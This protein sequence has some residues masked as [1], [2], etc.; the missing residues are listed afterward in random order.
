VKL[1]SLHLESDLLA[2]GLAERL[3]RR[4]LHIPMVL[5]EQEFQPRIETDS[6]VLHLLP[7]HPLLVVSRRGAEASSSLVSLRRLAGSLGSQRFKFSLSLDAPSASSAV[8]VLDCPESCLLE[9]SAAATGSLS[10]SHYISRHRLLQLLG[11]WPWALGSRSL[12]IRRDGY[13]EVR[14]TAERG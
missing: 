7:K 2:A 6:A 13:L 9:A 3:Q 11:D 14:R 5:L 10:E 4:A 1:G 8:S 12:T